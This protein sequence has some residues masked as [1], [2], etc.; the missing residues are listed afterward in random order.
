MKNREKSVIIRRY[1]SRKAFFSF[2]CQFFL[3]FP[4]NLNPV[5]VINNVCSLEQLD[6]WTWL[7]TKKKEKKMDKKVKVKDSHLEWPP[8]VNLFFLSLFFSD[9]V[10]SWISLKKDKKPPF[11]KAGINLVEC[12]LLKIQ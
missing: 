11:S 2:A 12:V 9:S 5:T 6:K 7:P 10:L 4:L 8:A 3:Y 1:L